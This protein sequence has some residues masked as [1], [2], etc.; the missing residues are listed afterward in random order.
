MPEHMVSVS[1]NPAK[2]EVWVASEAGLQ[3]IEAY[4]GDGR[5]ILSQE[6]N[7]L[8]AVL[9]VRGWASGTYLLRVTTPMG[10]T[11]K[12]LLVR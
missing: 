12:K 1:P 5:C 3:R 2:E 6:A 4:T 8:Q 10:T 7:G 9:D 11:T